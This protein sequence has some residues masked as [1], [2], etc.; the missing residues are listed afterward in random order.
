MEGGIIISE[1]RIKCL[2]EQVI[3]LTKENEAIANIITKKV[4]PVIEAII[5]YQK[6]KNDEECS[7]IG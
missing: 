5:L 7:Y 1:Q 2:E 4:N 6:V 3:R